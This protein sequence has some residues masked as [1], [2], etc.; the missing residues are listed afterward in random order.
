MKKKIFLFSFTFGLSLSSLVQEDLLQ[1]AEFASIAVLLSFMLFPLYIEKMSSVGIYVV[2]FKRTLVNSAK[3]FP[4]FLI[5]FTGFILSFNMRS[6]FGV[7]FFKSGIAPPLLPTNATTISAGIPGFS[8]LRTFTMVMGELETDKMGLNSDFYL[9]FL[10]YFMF[11]TVMCTIVLNLFVGIAVGEIKTVLDEA[12]IQRISMRIS[13]VLK[14]QSA[15]DPISKRL[16]CCGTLLNM[17]FK[18]YSYER[19]LKLI[20]LID[21]MYKQFLLFISTTEQDVILADPQKRLEDQFNQMSESTGE[22]IKSIKYG[23]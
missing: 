21:Q 13:F 9:N 14:I 18:S 10:I 5:L 22:Q 2:A 8:I 17:T 7:Q 6:N 16:N 12:D 20:K 23:I 3:F 19:D 1:R 11:L 4:I 15:I